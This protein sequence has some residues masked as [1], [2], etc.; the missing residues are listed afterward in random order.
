MASL[1]V[2]VS[3]SSRPS[4]HGSTRAECIGDKFDLAAASG[5]ERRCDRRKH[6]RV[7]QSF[8]HL[9]LAFEHGRRLLRVGDLEYVTAARGLDQKVQV[10]LAGELPDWSLEREQIRRDARGS[11]AIELRQNTTVRHDP[12]NCPAIIFGQSK[13]YTEFLL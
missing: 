9:V 13:N 8:E 2:S 3:P 4:I 12:P 11:V 6:A 5:G 10:A 7:G 1:Q